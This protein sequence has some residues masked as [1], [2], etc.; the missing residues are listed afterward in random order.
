LGVYNGNE[1]YVFVS[2]SHEDS[3]LVRP[4]IQ[5][6]QDRGFRVWYDEGIEVSVEWAKYVAEQLEQCCCMLA[7]VT[8]N[9]DD[10]PNCWQELTFAMEEK[11]QIVAIRVDGS[12]KLS[13]GMRMKLGAIQTMPFAKFGSAEKIL[14]SLS[15]AAVMKPC[16]GA[17]AEGVR[18][19]APTP[20]KALEPSAEELYQQAMKLNAEKEYEKAFLL[21]KKAAEQGYA[22]A[23]NNLGQCYELGEG[24]AQNK[25]EAVKWYRKSA[26]QGHAGAQCNLGYC[27]DCGE[28]VAQ[29]KEEAVKWYGKSAE[30]GH[31]RAQC[32][33][34]YCYQYGGGVAQNKEEAVKWYRK[35]AEQ[36]NS[37]AQNNLGYCYAYGEGVAQNKEEAVKWY[38]KSAEQG[39]AVAQCN[40]GLCYEYGRGVRKNKAE[41]RKWQQKAA[42]QG[43]A[44][45]IDALKRL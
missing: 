8:K 2:Y 22:D 15:Q 3:E 38:R 35:S 6:L 29:D 16:L 42:D 41:A 23:Q 43:Y 17:A 30:Q 7:Y 45:A 34:G 28:G 31:A 19:L 32:N 25:E 33:L 26:E 44:K 20:E 40:L 4:I 9:F 13:A 24:V 21:Y 37:V 39:H 11:K 14:E 1:P 27:Y 5:G 10:S 36:G 18:T 12:R